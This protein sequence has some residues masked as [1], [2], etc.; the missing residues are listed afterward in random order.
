MKANY[1]KFMQS[2][3][4]NVFLIMM[5]L[6]IGFVSK[7]QTPFST[8]NLLTGGNTKITQNKGAGRFDSGLIVAP[9][10]T[11]TATANL[12]VVSLYGGMLIRVLDT[13][14]MRNESANA[15]VKQR[16][17]GGGGA[18]SVLLYRTVGIDS[19]YLSVDGTTYAV[20]DSIGEADYSDLVWYVNTIAELES[21]SSTATTV[22][23]TDS[24]RGGVFNYYASGLTADNGIVFSATGKGSGYWKRQTTPSQ[25][26]NITWFGARP[27]SSATFNGLVINSLSAAG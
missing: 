11:D 17:V 1:S 24:L 5:V 10:F 4:K 8:P 19:I 13:L 14:W 26:V 2:N 7:A 22:I 6:V 12:S 15:W 9:R 23:V 18:G 21:Y 25:G 20:K 27:D 16:G 3:M